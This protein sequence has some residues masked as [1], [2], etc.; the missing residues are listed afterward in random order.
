[1]NK[2]Y[3]VFCKPFGV[4]SS[5]TDTEGRSTLKNYIPVPGIYSA[6]RLDYDSEGLLL[7]TDDGEL[8][9]KLTDPESHVSKTY[10]VQV[11]GQVSAEAIQKLKEGVEIKGIKTKRCKV[12]VIP[13]PNLAER[14]K[15]V[16]P[17]GMTTW[18]RMELREG[19]KRQIRH[20]TAAVGLPTLRI[21]RIA[22]GPI[23]I[24]IMAPGEWRDLSLD[25]IS[26]LKHRV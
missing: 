14:S 25:E 2:R 10:L 20:M 26:M 19:K 1:M 23:G 21:F 6:G 17:H 12:T 24:G 11:E 8:I 16:T 22:I 5:F 18:L 13:E 7:L 3:I 4:L 15:P 9:H